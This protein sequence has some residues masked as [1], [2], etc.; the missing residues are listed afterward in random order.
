M[1]TTTSKISASSQ[2]Y[3]EAIYELAQKCRLVRSIDIA[4]RLGVSRA[5][6]N[7]AI[8]VLKEM[9]LV[10]QE[11]YSDIALTEK[12]LEEAAYVTRRHQ[13]LKDFLLHV[14]GV[15]EEHAEKD[16][17]R[18]EHVI[19]KETFQKLCAFMEDWNTRQGGIR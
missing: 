18:M 19:T 11:R 12:G 4:N 14:L 3:L 9:G 13:V 10:T 15:S 16:A 6:V 8:G 7:R 2:D 5:S 1:N 17:C